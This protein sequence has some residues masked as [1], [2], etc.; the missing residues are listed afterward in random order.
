M[1]DNLTQTA[2]GGADPISAVANAL[3]GIVSSIFNY[4]IVKQTRKLREQ[5]VKNLEAQLEISKEARKIEVVKLL[6]EKIKTK[7]AEIET[8]TKTEQAAI[9]SQ[10]VIVAVIFMA[11]VLL[12]R[13]TTPK[14]QKQISTTKTESNGSTDKPV[15]L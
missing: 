5:E 13:P 9:W 8:D 3:N 6:Q 2:G 1:A 10:V 4:S 15:R 12:F 11:I 14:V 7:K